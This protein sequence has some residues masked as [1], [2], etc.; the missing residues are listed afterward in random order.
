MKAIALFAAIAVTT[1]SLV[2]MQGQDGKFSVKDDIG[3][4]RFSDPFPLSGLPSSSVAQQ[5]PDGKHFMVVTTR[6]L[7][8]DSIRPSYQGCPVGSEST[9]FVLPRRKSQRKLSVI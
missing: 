9:A 4:V 6:A 1:L 5:S 7:L 2:Q 3:M 8:D